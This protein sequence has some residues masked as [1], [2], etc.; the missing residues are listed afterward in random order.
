MIPEGPQIMTV[1]LNFL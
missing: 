1:P